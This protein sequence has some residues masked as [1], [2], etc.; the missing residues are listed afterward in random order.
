MSD[1]QLLHLA[2]NG[3]EDLLPEA[4]D[5]LLKELTSRALNHDIK[6]IGLESSESKSQTGATTKSNGRLYW[7][8]ILGLF[9]LIVPLNRALPER[10]VYNLDGTVAQVENPTG[11]FL[12]G[13][14]LVVPYKVMTGAPNWS[15]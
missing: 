1:D 8:I 14:L 13:V 15:G 12:M 6:E 5:V 7:G 4:R 9:V 2:R 10:T 11:L 3:G